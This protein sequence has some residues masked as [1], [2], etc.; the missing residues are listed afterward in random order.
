M[1]DISTILHDVRKITTLKTTYI[2]NYAIEN[3][4]NF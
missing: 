2:Y 3:I 4:T 1:C